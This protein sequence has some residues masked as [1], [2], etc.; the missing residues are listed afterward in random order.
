MASIAENLAL[1]RKRIARAAATA[2]RDPATV[3]LLAVSKRHPVASLESAF[4][5]GQRM[6]GENRVQELVAKAPEL[7]H[8]I[9]IEWHMIG[10][11]QTNK[12]RDLVQVAGLKLLHSLDR[13]KLANVL[14]AELAA[15]ERSLDVLLQIHATDDPQKHGCPPAEAFDLLQHVRTAAPALR[16]RG[17]MAMG[18]LAGDPAPVFARVAE[19]RRELEQAIGAGLP[20]L[21]LGMSNDLEVAVAAG[22]TMVRI[23]TAVFGARS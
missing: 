20:V 8:R 13:I 19:L 18:P 9:G 2:G 11:L 12:A 14:Q 5:A 17:L 3:E 22:S 23:G 6:F 21:S 10:S 4:D 7:A 15:V 16:V 1:V